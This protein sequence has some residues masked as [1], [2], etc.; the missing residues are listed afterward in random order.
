MGVCALEVPM[1]RPPLSLVTF[2]H[3]SMRFLSIF[4]FIIIAYLLCCVV[5]YGVPLSW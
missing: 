5:H 1:A 4:C 2:F 3:V